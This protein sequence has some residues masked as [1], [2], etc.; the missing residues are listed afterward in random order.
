MAVQT[1]PVSFSPS[2]QVTAARVLATPRWEPF[3]RAENQVGKNEIQF[4][5][6][7]L[8]TRPL[9][10]PLE[11]HFWI[12]YPSLRTVNALENWRLVLNIKLTEFAFLFILPRNW[13]AGTRRFWLIR[14]LRAGSR[15]AT[16]K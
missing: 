1:R 9:S 7:P 13:S 5:E 15:S 11:F 3:P 14:S 4:G 8:G 16:T 6:M 12:P 2:D 10:K